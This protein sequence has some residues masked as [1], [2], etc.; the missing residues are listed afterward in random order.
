L[1]RFAITDP[2][3]LLGG[4]AAS[5]MLSFS[6]AVLVLHPIGFRVALAAGVSALVLA[7]GLCAPRHLLYAL[8]VWLASL[9]LVR[10]LVSEISPPGEADALLLVGPVAIAVL[11]LVAAERDGPPRRTSLATAVLILTGLVVAGALNPLQ[12]ELLTGI[13]GLLFVLVP[14]L[15]FWVG[16]KLCD[17]QTLTSV[18]K[19]TGVVAIPA[20]LYG[21][22]QVFVG[23]PPWDATWIR[24]R[25]Y[26]SL[27]VFAADVEGQAY[28][29]FASFSAASEFSAFL[30]V[31]TVIW[32]GYRL[33]TQRAAVVVGVLAL[34]AVTIVYVSARGVVLGVMTAVGLMFAAKR[35]LPLGAAFLVV[36]LF[37]AVPFTVGRV[38]SGAVGG[39]GAGI[40]VAHQLQGFSD[41]LDPET[42]TIPVHL[43]II[44]EGIRSVAAEPLGV[45]VGAVTLAGGKFG[46]Y[47]RGTEADVS[48]VAVALGIPGLLAYLVFVVIAFARTYR[49]AA[50]RQEPLALV[51]LGILTVTLLQWLNGGHYGVAFLPWLVL[52]WVERTSA[53][54]PEAMTSQ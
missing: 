14:M 17:N 15:A 53:R 2:F 4:L 19:L 23:F 28:R 11:L 12:G 29:P 33:M 20:A 27:A 44:G 3:R 30:G 34:L 50:S 26:E 52:G 36:V 49:V 7:I 8:V 40:L 43:A 48:N 54:S 13:A 41:P 47:A 25:G 31:A 18:V 10:R 32:L 1:T 21:L 45:G 46:D 37:L 16:R 9:G 42:S 5:V 51:A 39:E 35:R 38:I 22:A 6:V 24:E